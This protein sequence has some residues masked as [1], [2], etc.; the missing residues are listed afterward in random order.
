MKNI[1]RAIFLVS[2]AVFGERSEPD[3]GRVVNY[4][5]LFSP[6]VVANTDGYFNE[7]IKFLAMVID[8]FRNEKSYTSNFKA[9]DLIRT[10][11]YLGLSSLAM[12]LPYNTEI[13]Q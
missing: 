13:V 10:Y 5:G 9:D 2:L 12:N 7:A 1:I 3:Y 8:R 11:E 6:L 4:Y